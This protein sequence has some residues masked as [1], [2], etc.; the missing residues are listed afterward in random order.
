MVQPVLPYPRKHPGPLLL[1]LRGF[2]L[3]VRGSVASPVERSTCRMPV[4]VSV[5]PADR[6][7]LRGVNRSPNQSHRVDY[8]NVLREAKS[9]I[10]DENI[11]FAFIHLP[12]PHP[13]GIFADPAQR[14]GG[15][16]DYL[17]NLILADQALAHFEPRLQRLPPHP[18][19]FSSSPQTIPGACRHGV[20]HQ[21]GP[22]RR[23]ALQAEARLIRVP[24]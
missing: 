11:R 8:R 24:C 14:I 18:T 10:S 20:E 12:V 21:A 15:R 22:M 23:S 9:L 2:P 4:T 1:E 6:E 16:E 19:R 13:P 3:A 5:H 17:G 7:C